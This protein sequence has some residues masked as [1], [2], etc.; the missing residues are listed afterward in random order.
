MAPQQEQEKVTKVLQILHLA[1]VT[2]SNSEIV[3]A[4]Q[5]LERI[6][7]NK[8][9]PELQNFIQKADGLLLCFE[10]HPASERTM[11]VLENAYLSIQKEAQAILGSN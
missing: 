2:K 11:N 7:E 6:L 1:K 9:S 5:E 3:G 10:N 4:R 8:P